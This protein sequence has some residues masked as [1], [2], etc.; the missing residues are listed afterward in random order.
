MIHDQI[1]LGRGGASL[2]EVLLRRKQLQTRYDYSIEFGFGYSFGSLNNRV[3]NP[4]FGN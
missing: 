4:V 3:V 1:F 2:E